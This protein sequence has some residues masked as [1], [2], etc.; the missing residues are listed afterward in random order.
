[1]ENGKGEYLSNGG[2]IHDEKPGITI[3]TYDEAT[4]THFHEFIPDIV[5]KAKRKEKEPK[6]ED[7]KE[8][9]SAP[10]Y[11][12]FYAWMQGNTYGEG[13]KWVKGGGIG[14]DGSLAFNKYA[15]GIKLETY[16]YSEFDA[17]IN[18]EIY[19]DKKIGADLSQ[20]LDGV[21]KFSFSAL[22]SFKPT[23]SGK[24]YVYG[25][26]P[27]LELPNEKLVELKLLDDIDLKTGAKIY[28]QVELNAGAT[29]GYNTQGKAYMGFG[30]AYG[31]TKNSSYISN[32]K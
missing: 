21:N 12:R 18:F 5:V 4:D 27:H 13:E 29:V 2:Y 17:G 11:N 3:Y 7:K 20:S 24:L 16:S 15:I 32:A 10:I 22:Q 14:I 25:Q 6:T 30:F 26:S 28:G 1:M 23:L 9:H 31:G 19:F 8:D